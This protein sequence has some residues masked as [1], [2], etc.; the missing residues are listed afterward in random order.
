MKSVTAKIPEYQ[1]GI[2]N[3]M[4]EMGLYKNRAEAIEN[5]VKRLIRKEKKSLERRSAVFRNY[6][7]K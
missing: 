5:A 7:L 4:V 2:L 3:K 6:S 1:M